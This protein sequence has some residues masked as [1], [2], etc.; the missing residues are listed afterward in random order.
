M[1][2]SKKKGRPEGRPFG[3]WEW[4][5]II[6]NPETHPTSIPPAG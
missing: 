5:K 4:K 2:T 1:E 6:A 3:V